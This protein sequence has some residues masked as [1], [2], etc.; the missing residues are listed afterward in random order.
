MKF[1][2]QVKIKKS[3]VAMGVLALVASG[4]VYAQ[5]YVTAP[6]N[7][8]TVYGGLIHANN[9]GTN[10][11]ESLS[12]RAGNGGNSAPNGNASSL[13]NLYSGGTADLYSVTSVN[14]V[15]NYDGSS[16]GTEGV[17]IRSN[18]AGSL[19]EARSHVYVGSD[20]ILT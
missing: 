19:T 7:S 3:L 4:S 2:N 10:D 12:L 1:N 9:D 16:S 20:G 14:I 6:I 11:S 5:V 18:L 15:G 8:N 17:F 13:L